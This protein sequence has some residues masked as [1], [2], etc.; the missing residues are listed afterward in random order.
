MG[1]RQLIVQVIDR[2]LMTIDPL[3]QLGVLDRGQPRRRKVQRGSAS[4]LQRSLA[5]LAARC[6]NF[7]I[8]TPDND[9]MR[10]QLAV[11]DKVDMA[12]LTTAD[13]KEIGRAVPDGAKALNPSQ[14]EKLVNGEIKSREEGADR[15]LS[16][17]AEREKSGDADGA[18]LAWDLRH[19]EER[20]PLADDI[21]LV[22][23]VS[24]APDGAV[25]AAGIDEGVLRWLD[26][27]STV[28]TAQVDGAGE[29][30]SAAFSRDGKLLASGA[31]DGTFKI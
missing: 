12:V 29:L 13:G 18:V 19:R 15:Q 17:A 1:Q 7:A 11:T 22:L 28:R 9:A 23:A 20:T 27:R 2:L 3:Q 26:T 21:G 10:G 30:L 6:V 5:L 24:F 14:V 31:K 16:Q 4:Q 25:L 8:V